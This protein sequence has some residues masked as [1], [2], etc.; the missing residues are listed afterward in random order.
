MKSVEI[1]A[2]GEGISLTMDDKIGE[3]FL[4]KLDAIVEYFSKFDEMIRI[5]RHGEVRKG[6]PL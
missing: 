3:R 5:P 6:G 4:Q 1:V 2:P